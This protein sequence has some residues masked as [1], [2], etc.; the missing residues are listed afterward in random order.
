CAR[1]LH[2]REAELDL[3]RV[4]VDPLVH[5]GPC[6]EHP[7]RTVENHAAQCGVACQVAEGPFDLGPRGAGQRIAPL[8]RSHRHARDEP[9]ALHAHPGR[10]TD[11]HRT[12]PALCSSR[13]ST[14]LKP[15]SASTSSVCSPRVGGAVDGAGVCPESLIGEPTMRT[16]PSVGCSTVST[17]SLYSTCGCFSAASMVLIRP[18]GM[19]T[20]AR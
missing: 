10:H 20:A 14:P 1:R 19:P 6:A 4:R 7:M 11:A 13:M 9:V 3:V 2:A 5:V 15:S 12:T 17:M 16:S 8:A 18:A